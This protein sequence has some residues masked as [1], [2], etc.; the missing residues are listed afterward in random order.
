MPSP[1]KLKV[2]GAKLAGYK[3]SKVY[4]ENSNVHFRRFARTCAA[5]GWPV[6][7][8]TETVLE[9]YAAFR[10]DTSDINS[11]S[12]NTE[13]YGIK[14]VHEQHNY[15]LDIRKNVMRRLG[16]IRDGWAKE[17]P[18]GRVKHVAVTT[19]VLAKLISVLNP[20]IEDQQTIRALL[21]FAKFGLYRVSEYTK[22]PSGHHA[23]V[24]DIQIHPSLD[25]A[26]YIVYYFNASKMNSTLKEERGIARCNCPGC[27]PVHEVLKMLDHRASVSGDQPLFRLKSGDLIT[28]EF[29]NVMLRKLCARTDVLQ[30]QFVSFG[31]EQKITAHDLRKGGITDLLAKGVPD[32]IVTTLSR[33]KNLES[34]QVYKKLQEGQLK[35]LL[36]HYLS[37]GL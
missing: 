7:P 3:W 30:K 1:A 29:V 6:L 11:G 18:R 31:T 34:L 12:F 25:D 5:Y 20:A 37:D 28:P 32:S 4:R 9:L 8:T 2:I 24:R 15:E 23:L 26:M 36:D 13:L 21:C 22:G 10:F 16:R 17:R 33:H 35:Q 27:C 19:D 14:Q